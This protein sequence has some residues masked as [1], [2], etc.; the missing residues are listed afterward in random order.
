MPVRWALQLQSP[1]LKFLLWIALLALP[2]AAICQTPPASDQAG[3][4]EAFRAGRAAM[5]QND[6]PRAHAEFEK[7]VKLA[8]N[9]AAGHSALGSVLYAEGNPS[10]AVPA[11]EEARS[12]DP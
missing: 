11:L 6:L 7:V 8:P 9:V 3:A 2:S 10:A 4:T 5:E 1:L 12:L